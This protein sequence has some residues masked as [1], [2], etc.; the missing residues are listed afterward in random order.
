LERER[1]ETKKIKKIPRDFSFSKEDM[2]SVHL[3]SLSSEIRRC[4]KRIEELQV[5]ES[6]QEVE[7]TKNDITISVDKTDNRL[8]IF[9]PSIPDQSTRSFLKSHG[10][11]WSPFNK[12][13]QRMIS[14]QAFYYAKKVQEGDF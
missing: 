12:A 8:R 9:F 13:W 1:E 4:K 10:F 5:V 14:D 7:E 6:V 11:R 3:S 2:R